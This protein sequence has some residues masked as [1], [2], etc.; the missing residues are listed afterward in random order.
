MEVV[1]KWNG[2]RRDQLEERELPSKL[3]IQFDDSSVERNF[4]DKNG[5]VAI[6]PHYLLR[7]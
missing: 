3:Y 6:Q 2:L 4:K 1:R 7:T 5:W